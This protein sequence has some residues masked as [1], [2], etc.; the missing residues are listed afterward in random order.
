MSGEAWEKRTFGRF[1]LG[2]SYKVV[3]VCHVI[4][5]KTQ[6]N[7]SVIYFTVRRNVKFGCSEC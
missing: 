7:K 3:A 1:L 5:V 4:S 6:I 2:P